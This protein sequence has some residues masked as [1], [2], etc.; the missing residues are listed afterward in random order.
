MRFTLTSTTHTLMHVCECA[1]ME[2][3]KI[4]I[5]A[6]TLETQKIQTTIQWRSDG[7]RKE[8]GPHQAARARGRHT[9]DKLQKYA[10]AG[11]KIRSQ[12]CTAR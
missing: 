3:R 7:M 9:D 5:H 8:C 12:Y 10:R 1:K 11:I 4:N 6:I 2:P